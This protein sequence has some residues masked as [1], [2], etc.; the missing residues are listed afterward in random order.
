MKKLYLVKREVWA[1][2]IEKAATAKGTV[3]EIS[4]A[5]DRFQNE[6]QKKVGFKKKKP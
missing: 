1:T 3:Y 2:S 5:E 6:K 4:V